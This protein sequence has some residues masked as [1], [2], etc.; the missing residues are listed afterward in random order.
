MNWKEKRIKHFLILAGDVIINNTMLQ[1]LANNLL[2]TEIPKKEKVTASGLV[3]PG[4]KTEVDYREKRGRPE[5]VKIVAVGPKVLSVKVNDE[6]LIKGYMIDELVIDDKKY[7]VGQEDAIIG[8][9][10]D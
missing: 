4:D 2:M 3:I 5:I 10:H 9:I 8:I 7:L 1:P 6:V